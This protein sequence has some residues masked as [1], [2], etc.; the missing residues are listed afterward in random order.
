[1][2][3]REPVEAMH[4]FAADVSCRAEVPARRGGAISAIAIQRHYLAQAEKH[5]RAG[6][7]PPWAEEACRQW[8][9]M[10]DRLERGPDA[11]AR[12]L[13]WGIKWMLFRD[14]VQRRGF[15]WEALPAWS[16]VVEQLC[17]TLQSRAHSVRR[18]T[19]DLLA[20]PP[21][22]LQSEME[23]LIPNMCSSGLDAGRLLD[24]VR[25]RD[26]L[27]E[28]DWR[29]SQLGE[30]S[31]FAALDRAGGLDHHFPGVDNIQHAVA[32]PPNFGR[33]LLRGRKVTE[34]AANR[35]DYWCSWTGIIDTRRQRKLCLSDPHRAQAEWCDLSPMEWEHSGMSEELRVLAR[36]AIRGEGV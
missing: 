11:I 23:R 28:I 32:N 17:A 2:R 26:E 14:R 27:A 29:Y 7:M 30:G 1:V 24:F 18:L 25:L 22:N 6:F 21:A 16:S 8:R 35:R 19:V 3:L 5:L 12:T 9:G 31:L 33:A 10:L 20:N 4:T 13:D 36:A 15:S 34:L